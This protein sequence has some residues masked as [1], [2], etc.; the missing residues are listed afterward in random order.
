[1][2][3]KILYII[4]ISVLIAGTGFGKNDNTK[5]SFKFKSESEFK[6]YLNKYEKTF[7]YKA[8]KP[9][10]SEKEIIATVKF[11][12]KK[13]YYNELYECKLIKNQK[14]FNK[15]KIKFKNSI[16]NNKTA[17]KIKLEI[18]YNAVC[19]KERIKKPPKEDFQIRLRKVTRDW[20]KARSLVSKDCTKKKEETLKKALKKNN[21][22]LVEYENYK[23][24]KNAE[25]NKN[26]KIS[27]SKMCKIE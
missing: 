16:K 10:K 23:K 13:P 27:I 24:K 3:N 26:I 1:M 11:M 7:D 20:I 5:F 21:I 6:K 8:L 9:G 15:W 14:A 12:I 2:N 17:K 22:S 25:Y 18:V 4:I 19:R